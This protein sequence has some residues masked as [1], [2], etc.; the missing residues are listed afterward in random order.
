M[1]LLLKYNPFC[2]L[3]LLFSFLSF[4]CYA[5]TYNFI[6]YNV[7]EGLS[8][9]KV[10]AIIQ[11]T[12]GYLWIGTTGGG[13]CKFDGKTFTKYNEKDGLGGSIVSSIAED[14]NQ[15][16]WITSSWGGVSKF[17]GRKFITFTTSDGLLDNNNNVVFP[18]ND[19]NIWIGSPSGL[20]IY[21]NG[22]F[23]T[24][25]KKNNEFLGSSITFIKQDHNDAIW[26]GSK[27]GITIINKKD[28]FY[29][30]SK[31]GLPTT[32]ITDF[33][34]DDEGNYLFSTTNNGVLKLIKGSVA[35]HANYEFKNLIQK[36]IKLSI[37]AIIEDND[38][39]IWIAT[40]KNGIYC[41]KKDG[42][43]TNITKKNGLEINNIT[44]LF[45][46]KAGNLWIGTNGAG[47]IKMGNTAFTYF[48]NI[49]GLNN[50]DIFSIV[51]D[52]NDN[53]WVSTAGEGVF[54]YDG[55]T[56]TQYKKNNGLASNIVSASIKDKKGNLW[57]ATTNGLSRYK[58]GVFKTFT[59]KDG[60][61]S[62]NTK[63]LLLDKAGNLWIGTYG[64][65][66]VKYNYATFITYNLEKNDLSNNL[67]HSLFQ[68]SKGN[69][70]I[71]TS[72]GINRY[73]NG[74]FYNYCG[75]TGICNPYISSIAEDK[76]GNIWFGT[77]RCAVRYD[78]VDF[79][80]LTYKDGLSSDVI[81]LL[82]GSKR[83]KI[84]IGTNN[85]IDKISFNSYGIINEIKNYGL[86]EGFK[87]VECNSRA[88]Y[89]DKIGNLWI[90]TVKG[91]IE[92]SPSKDKENVFEPIIHINKVRLFFEDVQWLKYTKN[93]SKWNNLPQNLVLDYDENHLTFDFSAIN[94]T[95]PEYVQY[96]FKL[97]NFD[98]DWYP[99][100]SK[101]SATY[102]NL[103]PGNYTFK[104]KSRNNNQVWNQTPASFSFT[105]ATP[106]WKR[107]WFL[108][109]SI[110]FIS[111]VIYKISAYR[112]KHQ[113]LI[114]KELEKKV[115]E[116][117]QLIETQRNEKEVLLKEIHHRVK[118]NMQVINSLLSI[119]SNYTL[120]TVALELFDEAKNR[121]RS[122]ALIHEKMYQSGD[123]SQIYV[124]DY[125]VSLT[126]DLI[127][128]YAI[129][130]NI[131]LD[132]TIDNS[133][134][135]ID[136]LIPLGL[137]INEIISNSLKYAFKN[138]EKGIISIHLSIHKPKNNCTLI[139]GDNGIGMEKGT[140]LK[141]DGTSL[142]M[143]LI[144]VFV[145]QLDGKI[146]RL[147]KKGT[148]FKIEFTP[149][150]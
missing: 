84:W 117:T 23:R 3:F 55:K 148:F 41:L 94:L 76:S 51:K 17:N 5:Q 61:P 113:I 116:R 43:L 101:T 72:N 109:L 38:K 123:L 128:T 102:S 20:S 89:E 70:W 142:G 134:L 13:I 106:F 104:V 122:M 95:H 103:P 108:V 37:T 136:T 73:T 53:I 131:F 149:R 119:Q 50:P 81:Y 150:P 140:L 44:K 10:T 60:L 118:N 8:Q 66:L 25:S 111:Y 83:G 7:A 27:K 97:E 130:C 114:S 35:K 34:E 90:G 141:E 14:K 79:K 52:D 68:D 18:D 133:K 80:P 146:T 125:V 120:D 82:Y 143:E 93:L 139:I 47:L 71:G 59:T 29:I 112:E 28:T 39:S 92:Y 19:G 65:G 129:N 88:I 86:I 2:S 26:I 87:G 22:I 100:T 105:I 99:S 32:Y 45:T 126:N 40:K 132:L 33:L 48:D 15:N 46:D 107:W 69:I 63:S 62:N 42:S 145:E 12:R 49:K 91:L 64:K 135:G 4:T 98:E 1:K 31:N 57:F 58:N 138:A 30:S 75:Y 121:I 85:G 67:I 137:L 16:L 24:I 144:K 77:D 110:V 124:Q 96:S 78:G 147:D 115:T 21:S 54:K 74:I 11:D 9:S 36:K 56:S 6:N 127:A